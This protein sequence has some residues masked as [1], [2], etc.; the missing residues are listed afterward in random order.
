[1]NGFMRRLTWRVGRHIY[2]RARGEPA[3]DE[4]TTNGET[5][6][7]Q[8]ILAA[9]NRVGEFRALDIGANVGEWTLPLVSARPPRLRS[10]ATTCIHLF[11]PV[12]ATR[13]LLEFRLANYEKER[14]IRIH[15]SALSDVCGYGSINVDEST[16]GRS[17]LVVGGIDG[18]APVAVQTTTL[19]R[20]FTDFRISHA[21]IVKIDAEG[22]DL[23]ILRGG[24]ELLSAGRI[25]V[26]QFEYNHT[27]IY[28][29]AFLKDVFDLVSGLSYKI[30]RI[31]PNCIEILDE[32]HPELDRFFH[33][34]YLL[35]REPALAWFDIHYGKFDIFNTFA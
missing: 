16:G 34:N 32:W 4:I 35:V 12:P 10:Q 26:V 29:H 9:A 22:H 8:R 18:A 14:I 30:A 11:E 27:W 20:A 1:M 15:N 24:H 17:S 5:Y 2:C 6:V 23:A 31:R 7:Q 25:D 19:L 33:C 21:Q 13:A 28:S 3:R